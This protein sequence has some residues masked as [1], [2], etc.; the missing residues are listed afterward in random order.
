MI[1]WK[2]FLKAA[3]VIVE[4]Q[5]HS[6]QAENNVKMA[7]LFL[8]RL[9]VLLAFA[10]RPCFSLVTRALIDLLVGLAIDRVKL[11]RNEVA[12]GFSRYFL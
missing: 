1:A 6:K 2:S 3:E 7:Q 4:F 10:G 5:K 11:T 12:V 9:L 8:V